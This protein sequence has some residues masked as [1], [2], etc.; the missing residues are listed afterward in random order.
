[1]FARLADLERFPT[2]NSAARRVVPRLAGPP[3]AG[4]RYAM[5]RPLPQGHV[6]DELE[7]L[8]LRAILGDA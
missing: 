4:S 8:T 7:L 6:D 3:A 5:S 2:W 1:V